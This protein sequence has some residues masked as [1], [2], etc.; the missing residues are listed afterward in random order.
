MRLRSSIKNNTISAFQTDAKPGQELVGDLI[1]ADD[2]NTA[3]TLTYSLVEPHEFFTIETD[4]R[5]G[6]IRLKGES[7]GLSSSH[8]LQPGEYE[9]KIKVTDGRGGEDIVTVVVVVVDVD[10]SLLRVKRLLTDD[11]KEYIDSKPK[12]E[13]ERKIKISFFFQSR[14]TANSLKFI[15]MLF[16][17]MV[18]SLNTMTCK[19]SGI[20]NGIFYPMK[21]MF[22]LI[23]MP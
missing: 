23:Q 3:D 15:S 2:P 7:D 18:E 10:K 6:K 9:F 5:Y 8:R 14:Y 22:G 19:I 1:K 12:T 16:Y 21:N 11:L 4:G 13:N 17:I 20:N